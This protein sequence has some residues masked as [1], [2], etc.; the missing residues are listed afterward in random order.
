MIKWN[1]EWMNDNLA[2]YCYFNTTAAVHA[3]IQSVSTVGSCISR[4]S[5]L[6]K[7]FSIS[8]YSHTEYGTLTQICIALVMLPGESSSMTQLQMTSHLRACYHLYAVRLC[9]QGASWLYLCL[10]VCPCVCSYIIFKEIFFY[11][12]HQRT[13]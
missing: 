13:H 9:K 6:S 8:S 12:P 5:L 1:S 10:C 11:V 2:R 3:V 4:I 7:Q